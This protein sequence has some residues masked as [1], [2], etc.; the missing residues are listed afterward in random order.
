VKGI[1]EMKLKPAPI[2]K[3][4]GITV[5]VSLAIVFIN[6]AYKSLPIYKSLARDS[7]WIQAILVHIPQFLISFLLI[8]Y[9]SKGKLGE[10]GFNLKV[11]S[12]SLSHMRMLSLGF[13]FGLLMSLRYIPQ[14]IEGAPLD[15]PQPVTI[16][17]VIGNMAFQWIVVGISEETLFRG[18]F[19]TFLLNNL[20]G[21]VKVLGHDLHIGTVIGAIIWGAFH[22]INI[23]V[24]PLGPVIFYVILTTVIGLPMGYAYQESG[25]ILT[26]VI[27]HNMIFGVPLTI[28]YVLYWLL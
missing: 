27:V 10:Y 26:T 28:G 3:V 9:I 18:L 14:I 19:Q 2:L 25:S 8:C 13:F 24:M 16:S 23:L 12:S 5:I 21:C 22:F 7:S 11:K 6:L 1:M 17:S 15:I 4:I 20:E